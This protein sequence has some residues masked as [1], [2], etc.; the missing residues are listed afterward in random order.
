MCIGAAVLNNRKPVVL[1]Y[2][3]EMRTG[4]NVGVATAAEQIFIYYSQ[5]LQLFIGVSVHKCSNN[6]D[7]PTVALLFYYFHKNI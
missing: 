7:K 1:Y 5:T 4:Q 3:W 2:E 6:S